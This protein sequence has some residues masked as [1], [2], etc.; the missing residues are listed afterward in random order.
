MA[1]C[2]KNL[3]NKQTESDLD[4][5]E[6][7][8]PRE[9]FNREK[10]PTLGEVIGLVRYESEH[11]KYS[12]NEAIRRAAEY[13]YEHWISQNVYSVSKPS[14]VKRLKK[15]F[16]LFKKLKFTTPNK[17]G[18]KWSD[19]SDEFKTSVNKLFDIFCENPEQR[20]QLEHTYGIPMLDEDYKYLNSMRTDR[21]AKCEKRKDT[22]WHDPCPA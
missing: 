18:K 9:N 2:S 7:C 10:L 15:K 3:R 1:S 20:T 13:L 12:H 6:L 4:I 19:E 22:Q 17:R 5:S 11:K 21:K 16:D 8:P 14:I